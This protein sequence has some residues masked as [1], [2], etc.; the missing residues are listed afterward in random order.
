MFLVLESY[1]PFS[2]FHFRLSVSF[3]ENSIPNECVAS[4]VQANDQQSECVLDYLFC[5]SSE[6]VVQASVFIKANVPNVII[7]SECAP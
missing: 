7:C 5:L 1:S 3:S 4:V 2:I 6:C